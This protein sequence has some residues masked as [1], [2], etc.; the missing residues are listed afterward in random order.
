[1]AAVLN[2]HTQFVDNGGSPLV[3][4]RMFI[5][6]M[7][8]EPE[9]N[10]I[11]VY[12]DRELTTVVSQVGGIPLDAQGRTTSKIWVP[13]QYSIKIEDSMG[14]QI[15]QELDNG[16]E[17]GVIT[18]PLTN[19]VGANAITADASPA[20]SA[21]TDN[22]EFIFEVVTENTANAVTL[23]IG[24]LPPKDIKRDFDIDVGVGKFKVG[25]K[26]LVIYNLREDN[27]RWVNVNNRVF[28]SN[29]AT[30]LASAVTIDLMAA[31]GNY[32][33]ISGSV[34]ISAF[35]NSVAG[36]FFTLVFSGNL[37][38]NHN[39]TSLI[40]PDDS[41]LYVNPGDTV[42][43]VT[44]DSNNVRILRRT[45]AGGG[46]ITGTVK[47]TIRATAPAG[48]LLLNGDTIGNS[49]S[50]ATQADPRYRELYILL[51]DSLAD[52]Q[53]PVS[54]GRGVSGQVDFSAG[55]TITMPDGR[56]RVLAGRNTAGTFMNM[57]SIG[58]AETVT[59]SITEM[60]SHS[61][62]QTGYI[63]GG[64]AL[65]G[66]ARSLTQ[67]G[68]AVNVDHSTASTGGDGAHTN[69]QPWLSLNHIIKI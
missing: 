61:H 16:E 50:G 46:D 3:N 23:K 33:P 10:P 5:G 29:Q 58:G 48:W 67:L 69:L 14:N 53:A 37:K 17:P 26:I 18:T 54:T 6:V 32:V 9:A 15:Y 66:L 31:T 28:Y 13:G 41:D 36:I 19:V 4:G 68:Q 34:D 43:M 42:E 22:A 40:T 7:D 2:E 47:S 24:L 11:T 25:D 39:A 1:M 12:S 8:L 27:F 35:N 56:D 55:K 57:G 49:G 20:I 62:I 64:G 30:I 59:N 63:A 45:R 38:I 51:W 44:L 21:L 65:S 60:P 52:A